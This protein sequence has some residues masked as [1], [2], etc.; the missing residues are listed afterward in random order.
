MSL[1]FQALLGHEIAAYLPTF[2]TIRSRLGALKIWHQMSCAAVGV[3]PR[4]VAGV[5]GEK[6]FGLPEKLVQSNHVDDHPL[7]RASGGNAA[8]VR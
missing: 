6:L 3:A 8:T 1:V 4:S 2:I 7:V 5:D